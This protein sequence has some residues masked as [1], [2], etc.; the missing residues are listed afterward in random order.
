[1]KFSDVFLSFKGSRIDFCFKIVLARKIISKQSWHMLAIALVG[2]GG[3]RIVGFHRK[4]CSD[5]GSGEFYTDLLIQR[6][7][8]IFWL[9]LLI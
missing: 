8:L 4:N 1:M 2:G 6:I 5:F 7:Y 3:F 9:E